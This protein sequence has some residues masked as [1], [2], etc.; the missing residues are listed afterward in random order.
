M[1]FYLFFY[2][3]CK[4]IAC[5]FY[6]WLCSEK[7]ERNEQ[8][9]T[10]ISC[11]KFPKATKQESFQPLY[12]CITILC[13]IRAIAFFSV[14]AKYCYASNMSQNPAIALLRSFH[15]TQSPAILAQRLLQAGCIIL[16]SLVRLISSDQQAVSSAHHSIMLHAATLAAMT[17]L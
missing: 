15:S 6:F 3:G 16:H 13:D 10:S 7:N 17:I 4:Q 11:A 1:V 12:R 2:N 9:F 8:E 14:F 5:Q